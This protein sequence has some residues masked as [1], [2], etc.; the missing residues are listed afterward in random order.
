M[1]ESSMNFVDHMQSQNHHHLSPSLRFQPFGGSK[2]LRTNSIGGASVAGSE[3]QNP[4]IY[5][6]GHAPPSEADSE[7]IR[8]QI[9]QNLI[10]EFQKDNAMEN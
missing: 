10:K 9:L 7:K 4:S 5:L 8:R 1:S 6:G 3:D 2:L